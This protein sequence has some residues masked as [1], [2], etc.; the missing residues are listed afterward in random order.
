MGR[1]SG[2]LALVFAVAVVA[3]GCGSE[4]PPPFDTNDGNVT[5]DVQND[6]GG[7]DLP[8]VATDEG[9]A[10][11]DDGVATDTVETIEDV[12]PTPCQRNSDCTDAPLTVGTCQKKICDTVDKV[13]VL[14]W[15]SECCMD[16]TYLQVGFEDGFDDWVLVDPKTTDQVSWSLTTNRKAFGTRSAYFGNA[17]CYTYYSGALNGDCDPVDPSGADSAAVRAS[18]TSPY[19]SIP[20]ISASKTTFIASAYIWVESEP[21][22]TGVDASV[23]P[24][25]FRVSVVTKNLDVETAVQ[26]ISSVKVDK[27]TNG[28]FVYVSANISA[29][30]GKEIAIRLSFDSIDGSNNNYEGVYVDEVKVFSVCSAQCDSG[31]ECAPDSVECSDDSCQVFLDRVNG[32]GACSYPLIPTC[33]E[34]QCTTANVQTK[35]VTD[36]LCVSKSCV[37]G[38]CVFTALPENEC[39]RTTEILS[40]GFE[41][42][43]VSEFYVWTYQNEDI[44]KW[45]A[46]SYKSAEGGWS[47]YYGDPITHTYDTP[48]TFNFGDATTPA[49]EL[50][51]NNYVFLTFD[52]FLATEWDGGIPASYYN[53]G[54]FDF[55]QV[56]VVERFGQ[57]TEAATAVWTSHNVQGTTG[58]VFLPVGIDL[59]AFAG[60]VVNVRFRFDTGNEE[61]NNFEGLY[62]DNV[63]VVTDSCIHKT[64][65]T[66]QDCGIDGVCKTGSCTVANVCNIVIAGDEGCCSVTQDCDDDDECTADGCV[67][68]VCLHEAIEQPGCCFEDVRAEY[69]FDIFGDL[70]GFAVVNNST[71]ALGGAEVKWHLT[72]TKSET[73]TRSMYFGNS[74][75]GNYE[76]GG[77]ARGTATSPDI[78]VPAHGDY[79]LSFALYLDVQ[80]DALKDTFKIEVMDGLTPTA[81]FT[82]ASVPTQAY[83]TWFNV[84]GIDMNPWKGKTIKLR[85]T[86]D[87]VDALDNTGAGVFVDNIMVQR[88][89]I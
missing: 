88:N 5:S 30:V 10:V 59:S 71:P 85:F 56:E 48:G 57:E 78:S 67:N 63:K 73:G 49:L 7:N 14:D 60:K 58:G 74:T 11:E 39:C 37:E 83:E 35:C 21:M 76:N 64:C 41:D 89:C 46:S 77:I 54:S 43:T 27:N 23:Q 28:Q 42:G 53:P 50:P 61:F 1:L 87:S 16:S 9:V 17:V 69:T 81:V 15:D 29:F 62:L 80:T 18:I 84:G 36:E 65:L 34:P 44:V 70:D 4:S 25:Q 19:F 52:M 24:D 68:N 86:F 72:E 79:V 38:Q 3:S 47:L 55:F 31:T 22:I 6:N 8:D 66:E 32:K 2:L 51:A 12:G 26:M 82:K 20:S 13:C 75:N 45:R 33:V 40:E